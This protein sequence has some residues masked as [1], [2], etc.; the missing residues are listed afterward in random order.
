MAQRLSRPCK[1]VSTATARP[2][3]RSWPTVCVSSEPVRPLSSIMPCGG[4]PC[5]TPHWPKPNPQPCFSRAAKWRHRSNH[6]RSGSSSPCPVPAPS[7]RSYTGSPPC[8]LRYRSPWGIRLDASPF[9]AALDCCRSTDPRTRCHKSVDGADRCDCKAPR[10]GGARV[11]RS[12]NA[13]SGVKILLHEYAHA[14]NPFR[15]LAQRRDSLQ[16]V[17][18]TVYE[19]FRLA[20]SFESPSPCARLS[21]DMSLNQPQQESVTGATTLAVR[22]RQSR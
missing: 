18:A 7:R 20:T 6:T 17:Q 22:H 4:I 5:S 16:H 2:R 12:R 21:Q 19:I 3:Q 1:V 13:F 15:T 14:K 9:S 10:G 11:L 8:Y